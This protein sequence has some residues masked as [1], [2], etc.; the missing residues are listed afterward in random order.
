MSSRVVVRVLALTLLMSACDS[1]SAP[2]QPNKQAAK[3]AAA[4]S[5]EPAPAPAPASVPKPTPV[6]TPEPPPPPAE[7]APLD[8]PTTAVAPEPEPPAE[9]EPAP[10]AAPAP[11]PAPSI[12][13]TG[14]PRDP[15]VI[16]PGTPTAH[17]KAFAKLPVAKGDGPP[18]GGI[19][20]NGIHIDTLEV[21]KDWANSKCDQV[22][23]VFTAGVDEKVNV[24]MRVIHQRVDEELTIVWSNDGKVAQR[25]K[26][27]VKAIH[28]YLTRGWLPVKSERK[29]KWKASIQASDGTVLGEAEF[30]IK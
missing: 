15:S 6:E 13:K 22:G 23:N 17:A 24:C 21:G 5:S 1:P 12:A 18:I 19:G 20:P 8:E 10:E 16:P 2:K 11:T 26:V 30:E 4:K 27:Q 29:G 3:P 25:S 9:P 14:D 28:A 7:R